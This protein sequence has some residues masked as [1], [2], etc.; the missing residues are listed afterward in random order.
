M[1]PSAVK[2]RWPP[3]GHAATN[4]CLS[5]G[6]SSPGRRRACVLFGVS[7]RGGHSPT[8]LP[9]DTAWLAFPPTGWGRLGVLSHHSSTPLRPPSPSTAPA[10]PHPAAEVC[11]QCGGA[12][13]S[14]Q[15]NSSVS[16]YA[17]VS[18]YVVSG[19]VPRRP[20]VIY[21]GDSVRQL[22]ARCGCVNADC[23]HSI[24]RDRFSIPPGARIWYE[25]P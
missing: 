8:G 20:V 5:L 25:C 16:H 1:A 18:I 15:P 14:M 3:C 19:T 12:P 23:S 9:G 21:L 17:Q 24:G 13:H 4:S 6:A 7:F 22:T 2:S 11:P 10:A